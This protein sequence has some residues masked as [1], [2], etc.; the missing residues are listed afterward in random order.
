MN[1]AFE[2]VRKFCRLAA[3]LGRFIENPLPPEQC[4]HA[5]KDSIRQREKEFLLL[6]QKAVYGFP[7]SPYLPLLRWAGVEFADVERMVLAEGVESAMARLYD[8]G[9]HIS[10]EQAKGREPVSRPGLH[11]ATRSEDFDNPLLSNDIDV[12]SGGSAGSPRRTAVNLD[13]VARDAPCRFLAHLANGVE[14]YPV[15]LWRTVPPG[16]AGIKNALEQALLRNPAQRWFTPYVPSWKRGTFKSA[17]L[18][19]YLVWAGR[20]HGGLIPKPEHAPLDDPGR[21]VQ[22]LAGQIR[23]GKPAVFVTPASGAVRICTAATESGHDIQGTVFRVGGEPLTK[24]KARLI[25]STGARTISAWAMSEAGG[26]IA[27]ACGAREA[28]DEVHIYRGKISLLARKKALPDGQEVA[29][30]LYMTTLQTTTS[31]IMLNLETGD[32][33]EFSQRSCGCLLDKIGFVDHLHTIRSYEKLTTGGMS[34]LGKD[35]IDL[36]EDVLPGVYGGGPMDYQ[37]VEYE[38]EAATRIAILISPRIDGI[39]PNRVVETALRFLAQGN[40]ANRMMADFWRQGQTLHV[41][42]SDP[43]ATPAGKILPLRILRGGETPLQEDSNACD[44]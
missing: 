10:I 33:G 13:Q 14:E 43:Y 15:G 44:R 37:F 38:H 32:Y 42:R 29:N 1:H 25:E 6:L 7:K 28:V 16:G 40:R 41:V 23:S 24:A 34:F 17:L 9:V 3:R 20:R 35:V 4:L 2:D 27:G 21:I 22:W 5:V 18:T 36:V 19:S 30:A 39:D 11:Y 31:K 26:P 12:Q 8:A